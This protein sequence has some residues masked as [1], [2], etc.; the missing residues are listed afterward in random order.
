M[1]CQ[2]KYTLAC[3]GIKQRRGRYNK[4]NGRCEKCRDLS[5]Q[6]HISGFTKNV[7]QESAQGDKKPIKEKD[8]P[9]THQKRKGCWCVC[10]RT[11][12]SRRPPTELVRVVALI[13][14]QASKLSHPIIDIHPSYLSTCILTYPSHHRIQM[15]S[16]QDRYPNMSV[17]TYPKTIQD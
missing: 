7:E 2:P 14:A 10:Q 9:Q 13:P 3:V 6:A 17:N 5:G 12:P 15:Q 11:D 1:Q 16:P 8:R 4:K